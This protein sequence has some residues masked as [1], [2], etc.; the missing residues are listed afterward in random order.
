MEIIIREA[1]DNDCM[2]IYALMRNELNLNVEYNI[3]TSQIEKMKTNGN[4]II[5][6]A[7]HG[8]AVIGFI[9]AYK[10]MILE[11]E[12]EYMRIIGLSVALPYR[13]QGIGTQLLNSV[14][15]F[16]RINGV[17]YIALNSLPGLADDHAFFEA[18]GFEK[19]SVCFS[20]SI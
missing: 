16:A 14:T 10:A 18:N 13:R 19:K 1:V 20:K 6:T 11:V 3:I 15:N 12:N 17:A 4:Y 2:G 7:M 5:Y 8:D 9:T